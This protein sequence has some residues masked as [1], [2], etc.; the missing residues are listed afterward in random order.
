MAND[1]GSKQRL[2]D[3]LEQMEKDLHEFGRQ[4]RK[5]LLR[6]LAS[7]NLKDRTALFSRISFRT[8]GGT[9]VRRE[10]PLINSITSKL[11]RQD[12][13]IHAVAWG[14]TRH[15][16][17]LEHGVGRGRPVRSPQA[18][19]AARPWL[20]PVLNDAEDVLADLL[21]DRYADIVSSEVAI[22]IPGVIDTRTTPS[23]EYVEFK[24]KD[25]TIKI[26]IDPSFF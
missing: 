9:R 1:F 18:N 6:Q 3:R 26:L 15:G 14:F 4:T 17:F 22:T 21:A 2:G 13:S 24:E 23:T 10:K 19:R 7:L 11:R 16:I 5:D 8:R 25:K 20:A 12:G